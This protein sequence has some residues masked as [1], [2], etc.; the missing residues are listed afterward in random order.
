[1]HDMHSLPTPNVESYALSELWTCFRQ[2]EASVS[3]DESI[4]RMEEF[5]SIALRILGEDFE[6]EEP[7]LSMSEVITRTLAS[8][9][10]LR[11]R[12][13]IT[14]SKMGMWSQVAW[15]DLMEYRAEM[16]LGRLI[17]SG[18]RLQRQRVENRFGIWFMIW[19]QSLQS[20]ASLNYRNTANGSTD[21][22]LYPTDHQKELD[23]EEMM[24]MEEVLGCYSL[25]LA[26]RELEESSR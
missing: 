23:F 16:E 13:T 8:L 24:L 19:I 12:V 7:M 11:E 15:N 17:I 1:M 25:E 9:M 26:V 10:A 5:T 4:T 22:L 3:L 18:A 14:Q 6:Q 2:W 21:T 20:H